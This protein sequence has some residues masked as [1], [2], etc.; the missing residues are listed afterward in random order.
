[1]LQ[2]AGVAK[3]KFQLGGLPPGKDELSLYFIFY[4]LSCRCKTLYGRNYFRTVVS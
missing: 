4:L 2:V 3:Q 1:M